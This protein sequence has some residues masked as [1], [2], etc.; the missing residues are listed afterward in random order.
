[1]FAKRQENVFFQTNVQR[2]VEI[3]KS[4]HHAVSH[5]VTRLASTRMVHLGV[6]PPKGALRMEDVSVKKDMFAKRQ[7]NVFFQTNVQRGVEIMKS[8][9][10]AVSHPVMRLA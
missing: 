7:E 4:S 9:H 2:G 1:M 10:H 5:P 6:F 3:M 8:S